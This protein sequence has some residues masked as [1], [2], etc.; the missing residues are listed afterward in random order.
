VLLCLILSLKFFVKHSS[1]KIYERQFLVNKHECIYNFINT[2]NC[3]WNYLIGSTFIG[4]IQIELGRKNEQRQ[5]SYVYVLWYFGLHNKYY[6][7][8]H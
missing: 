5:N 8:D 4:I 7:L 3:N 6:F 2:C 1:S